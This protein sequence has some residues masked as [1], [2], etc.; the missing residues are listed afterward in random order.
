MLDVAQAL[1]RRE[2][3]EQRPQLSFSSHLPYSAAESTVSVLV[4]VRELCL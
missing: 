2:L 3:G 4:L 1:A